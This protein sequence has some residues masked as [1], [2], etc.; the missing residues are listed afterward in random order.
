[1]I[2]EAGPQANSTQTIFRDQLRSH[3][4]L[5]LSVGF[6]TEPLFQLGYQRSFS[7]R[8][9]I[10]N[11]RVF[12]RGEGPALPLLRVSHDADSLFIGAHPRVVAP[13]THGR[14]R[15]LAST[16]EDSTL[17]GSSSGFGMGVSCLDNLLCYTTARPSPS[18][19]LRV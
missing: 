17:T 13:G 6:N 18:E 1:L 9:T 5:P 10:L 7:P 3:P 15:F 8:P 14:S 4:I 19:A 12:L 16:P 2:V 11:P